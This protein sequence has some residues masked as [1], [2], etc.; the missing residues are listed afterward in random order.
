MF[1]PLP[2][3]QSFGEPRG[4]LGFA[5][6]SDDPQVVV[7]HGVTV[8]VRQSKVMGLNSALGDRRKELPVSCQ[9]QL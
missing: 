3:G 8:K 4:G 9:K 6:K 5:R 7:G 1:P 2:D